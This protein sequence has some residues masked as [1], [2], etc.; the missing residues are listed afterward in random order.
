M[1]IL[2]IEPIIFP[3]PSL[4][5]EDGFLA[6]GGDLSPERLMLAYRNGIFPW[7]NDGQ[8]IL[9]WS[10]PE[11]CVIRPEKIHVSHSMQKFM[12]RHKV[13]IVRNRDFAHTMHRC[14]EKRADKEGTWIIPEM[15]EA[16]LRLHKLG[17]ATSVEAYIDGELAG[18]LY[19]VNNSKV[20]CGESMYSD[21][22]N[23]SKIALILFARE[24]RAEGYELIDCQFRTDHLVSLGA[25]MIS[26][27]EYL[28]Y[29]SRT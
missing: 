10:P 13:E 8:P 1:Y 15:E 9:W 19:G 17:Y 6:V 26:R 22:E 16:Y 25:E 21:L 11:R 12:R 20:F 28:S 5:N 23:G 2:P 27:E 14:G 24:L 4:A 3:D 29:L 7:Y 18:G